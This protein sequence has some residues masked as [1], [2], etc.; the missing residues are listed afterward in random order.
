MAY[1]TVESY[2]QTK[3]LEIDE[4]S[5]KYKV[6]IRKNIEK[7]PNLDEEG[8]ETGGTHW[9]MEESIMTKEEFKQYSNIM[10]AIKSQVS[11]KIESDNLIIMEALADIYTSIQ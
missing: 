10:D 4:T 8:N 2:S 1:K 5:S 9:R 6:Y 7:V 11:D 3:P